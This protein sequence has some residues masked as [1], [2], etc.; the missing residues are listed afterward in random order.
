MTT[1][2]NKTPQFPTLTLNLVIPGYLDL[3]MRFFFKGSYLIEWID[4]CLCRHHF[5]ILPCMDIQAF[6]LDVC[7]YYLL[8]KYTPITGILDGKLH[9]Y[10]MNA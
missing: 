8:G 1:T 2:N 9:C 3:D 4:V 7:L 6:I 5:M 10:P